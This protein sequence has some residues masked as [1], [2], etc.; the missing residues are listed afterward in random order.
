MLK[1]AIYHRPK[2][3]FAYA[4]DTKTV[5]IRLR[6][7]KD[8]VT[9]VALLWGDPFTWE[10]T[11]DGTWQWKVNGKTVM[12]KLRSTTLFD[13]WTAD[14]QPEYRRLK[15]GFEIHSGEEKVVFTEKGFFEADRE[16]KEYIAGFFTFPFINPEDIFQAPAWVKE[17]VWYQIFPERFANGNP[18]TDQEGTLAWGSQKP[19]WDNFFGGDLQG[20]IDHIDHLASLG[21][22]GI[23][24]TPIFKAPSNHKYDTIDYMEIDPHFGDKETFKKLV[25]VCHANG[26][27]VML[28]AVFN[29]S[30]FYFPPFQDVLEHGEAS[31]YKDWFYLREFPIVSKPVPNYDTFAFEPKMPK[32]NTSNPELR[33]YLLE[34]GRYW[35][36]E[37]DIDGWRL[38]VANE[39]SHEFWREFRK[40][41]KAIKPDAYILGEIWH[42]A[43]P[44]L[45]GDQ[46]D[47]VMNYPYTNAAIQFFGES[48]ITKQQFIDE[49]TE[50]LLMYPDNVTEVAFNLLGSHDTPRILHVSGED[51]L[52][53]KQLF[54][55]L[56]SSPGT[57]CIYYGDEIGLTGA[58]DPDCRRCMPWNKEEQ[59]Q[60]MLQYMTRL[61]QLRKT[62]P[63]F[64]NDGTLTFVENAAD[65]N[66]LMYTKHNDKETLLFIFNHSDENIVVPVPAGLKERNFESLLNDEWQVNES[67]FI[68]AA[69][70]V[71]VAVVK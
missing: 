13:Y 46:F 41:V 52:K 49:T 56:L 22:N 38:D 29:H 1:E 23:Y 35:V 58:G 59:D 26:I 20:I 33:E 28:D 2:G 15:Y 51:K 31:K 25:E 11:E 61:I 24:L 66:Y 67:G 69:R 64:G 19:E 5:Q 65:D 71:V 3:N 34:V 4:I 40:E 21:I 30:G 37:F 54:T 43:M 18:T 53:V 16:A 48:K 55:F 10:Q 27:K 14:L 63:A 9:E 60:D 42:D 12:K 47:A 7:K 39:V 70:G 68:L 32:L 62:V 50:A 44:W 57:P 45:Q 17:T 6:T 36:R 8:D